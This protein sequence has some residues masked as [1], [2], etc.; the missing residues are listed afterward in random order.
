ML[1]NNAY[2]LYDVVYDGRSSIRVVFLSR[3]GRVERIFEYF[4]RLFFPLNGLSEEDFIDILQCAC[5]SPRNVCFFGSNA[6]LKFDSFDDLKSA[7]NS[8]ESFFG[9]RV[10]IV[11]PERQF[12]VSMG[13]SYFDLFV[14][15]DDIVC[16]P[17][18]AGDYDFV[19]LASE[20]L[21]LFG[22]SKEN[23][24]YFFELVIYSNLIRFPLFSRFSVGR[25]RAEIFLENVFFASDSFFEAKSVSFKKRF[26]EVFGSAEINFSRLV[27]AIISLPN[28]NLGPGKVNCFCCKPES[29]DAQNVLPS[30]LV[31][32]RFLKD[33]F[34]FNSISKSWASSFHDS[35]DFKDSRLERKREYSFDFFPVGPF[36]RNEVCDLLLPDAIFVQEQGAGFIIGVSS[37]AWSCF[38]S[39]SVLSVEIE[40]LRA[41]VSKA[42]CFIDNLS[43]STIASNGVFYS[44]ALELSYSF[45]FAKSSLH[46]CLDILGSLPY[47]LSSRE[48]GFFMESV[49]FSVDAFSSS[50]SREIE[51]LVAGSGYRSSSANG[52]KIL[53]GKGAVLSVSKK[54]SEIYRLEKG[55]LEVRGWA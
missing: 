55:L 11:E 35:H 33:G 9:F 5:V 6:C 22:N 18:F 41:F 43:V 47:L 8:L 23:V 14:F 24:R 28:V 46:A 36:F 49:A 20:L 48:S 52:S 40:K 2:F 38:K 51:R 32:V 30:S 53:V 4:P 31:K 12:L 25:C 3:H 19:E 7:A 29:V 16:F 39:R 37:L 10:G 27:S 1:P 21:S 54:L 42:N 17:L 44:Q 13:W 34:F 50:V 15:D 26:S 45:L